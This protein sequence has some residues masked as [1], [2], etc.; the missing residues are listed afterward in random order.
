MTGAT[1]VNRTVLG[2]LLAALAGGC[3][4]YG[5]PFET[6]PP[7]P[8]QPTQVTEDLK[9]LPEPQQQV[10][11]AVYRFRDQTGQHKPSQGGGTSFSTAVTQG[12][13]SILIGALEDSGWFVPI[14][15]AGLSNLMNERQIIQQIR[16][17]YAP[18]EEGQQQGRDLGQLRPLLY[19]G[20]LLEGGIIGYNTNTVTSG[21][22][23]RYFGAGGSGEYRQDQVTVYLRAVSTQTG[24]VLKTV[25]ATKTVLSQKVDAGIFR[26][27][28]PDRLLQAETGYSYNEPTTIAV[29]E[30]IEESVRAMVVEG[31]EGGLWSLADS[32]EIDH[33]SFAEYRR[34]KAQAADT[35]AFDLPVGQERSGKVL[36]LHLGGQRYQGNFRDPLART[37]GGVSVHH[38]SSSR[39]GLGLAVSTGGL[40]A[41]GGFDQTSVSAEVSGRYHFMPRSPL[42]PFLQGGLGLMVPDT[43]DFGTEVGEQLFPYAAFGGGLEYLIGRAVGLQGTLENQ[44]ALSDGIDGIT[45]GDG[46]DS[47][48][49]L[50]AGLNLYLSRF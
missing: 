9:N 35:N 44:Y 18:K 26:F 5:Q 47:V 15:R 33:P 4:S 27:V 25:H 50:T 6:E 12:A 43:D 37:G 17:Q 8:N 34:E 2:L 49:R 30:A 13:T 3:A 19:A 10:V 45:E 32:T 24:R 29:R 36:G 41:E 42:S 46:Q 20:V 23:A 28:E 22:A 38:M 7:R 48:W 1:A 16:Q 31:V 39:F 21:V 11:A 14:E 40:A